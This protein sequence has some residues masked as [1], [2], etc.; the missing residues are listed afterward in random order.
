MDDQMVNPLEEHLKTQ[1]DSPRSFFWHR[2]RWLALAE[3]LPK[4]KK[5][6]LLDIGAGAG[7]AGE[8]LREERPLA[9][10][11]FIE[12]L[13][14]LEASLLSRFG[15]ASNYA[16]KLRYPEVSH[17]TLLDVLEHQEKDGQFIS[18]LVEKLNPGV[19]VLLTVPAD[20]VFWSRWDEIFGHYRRYSKSNLRDVLTHPK[21][22]VLELSY[23][24]PEMIPLAFFRK[25]T[26][27]LSAGHAKEGDFP[28]LPSWLNRGLTLLGSIS[29]CLRRW[30]P[31]GTSLLA[32]MRVR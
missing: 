17:V 19:I 6:T 20:K 8:Y 14:S 2:L 22:E 18:E 13:S 10:Y 15:L 29:L 1:L 4:Q 26:S 21:L 9:D 16:N 3:W 27:R 11:K 32:V 30:M 25:W 5:I 24:F 31:F 12:P 23:L 28:S 7:F